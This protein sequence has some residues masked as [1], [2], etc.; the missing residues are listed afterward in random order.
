MQA[1][2]ELDRWAFSRS[3]RSEGGHYSRKLET[4]FGEVKMRI[5][6]DR[7]GKYGAGIANIQRRSSYP[8]RI[9]ERV[10]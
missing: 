10:D 9:R 4:A 2:L 7:E 1:L 5:P 6:L 3:R 8:R